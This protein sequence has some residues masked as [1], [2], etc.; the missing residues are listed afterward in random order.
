MAPQTEA[1]PPAERALDRL[2][3]EDALAQMLE[4]QIA[5]LEAVRPA[6][7]ALSAASARMAATLAGDGRIVYAAAGSPALMALADAAEQPGT[8]GLAPDRFL[9]LMAG[10]VPRDARMPGGPED[11]AD[12]AT[13]AAAALRPGD[14]VVALSASGTTAWPRAVVAAARRRGLYT[15]ALAS[16]AGSPL[17]ADADL[18]ILVETPPEALAGSTRL[19]AGTAQKAAL[20]LMSTLAA[21][22][23][24]HVHDGQMVNVVADNA[25]LRARAAAMVARTAGVPPETAAAHLAA[26]GGAVKPAI[27]TAAGAPSP[28]AAERLLA[29][30]AGHLRPALARLTAR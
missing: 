3:P 29:E 19:G 5:A 28:D 12:A 18:P 23:L 8:F 10:G 16:V 11:D 6:L 30:C 20:N 4:G 7:P 2:P 9:L 15:V 26:T 22:R 17:L 13:A 1:A 27:L 21:V 25:K 14:L 24:G